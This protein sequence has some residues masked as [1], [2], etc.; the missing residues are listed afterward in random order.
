MRDDR[1]AR[2]RAGLA[3]TVAAPTD[4]ALDGTLAAP[5]TD[6][7]LEGTLAA[8][9]TDPSLDGTLAAPPTRAP[10]AAAEGLAPGAALGRYVVL[11]R[12]GAGGMGE[13]YAAY[14]PVL[15]R[16]IAV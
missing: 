9:A 11:S 8:P 14:D 10:P 5:A 6:P 16:R 13:V 1:G 2:D 3:A 15:D 12:L 7:A 4:P